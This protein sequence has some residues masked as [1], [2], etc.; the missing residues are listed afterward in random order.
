MGKVVGT[1]HL[2]SGPVS[3]EL[4]HHSAIDELHDKCD[5]VGGDFKED[6]TWFTLSCCP[7]ILQV[8][9]IKCARNSSNAIYATFRT[10]KAK[11]LSELV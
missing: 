7:V 11:M 6:L 9:F 1:Y 3:F 5:G 4:D 10:E 2:E 8:Y